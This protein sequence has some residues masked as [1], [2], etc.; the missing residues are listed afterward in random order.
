MSLIEQISKGESKLLEFKE[1]IP[2]S[3][4]L[5]K[6]II[7]FANTGGGKILIGVDDAGEI[8]GIP[9]QELAALMDRVA[10]MVHDA[11]Q[12][13]LI[14][15]IYTFTN[16]ENTI[17]VVEVYP[18]QLRPHYLKAKGK[19]EGTYIRVGATT[20]KAD[21]LYIAELERQKQNISYDEEITIIPEAN[22]TEIEKLIT[23]LSQ[24]MPVQ[25][26]HADLLNLKLIAVNGNNTYFT[27]GASILL[28]FPENVLIQCGRF[29]GV[30]SNTF[31][32][33]KT[34]T[35]DLF[36]QLDEAMK[37]LLANINL[38][39]EVGDDFLY[40]VDT[41][42]IPPVALR[43]ALLNAV[44]HRDYGTMNGDIKIAVYDDRIE[45]TSPGGFPKGVTV[46][47]AM[48]G[49]SEIRNRALVR[50]FREAHLIEQWGRG[51]YLMISLCKEAGLKKPKIVESGMF[52]QVTFYRK[53][54]GRKNRTQKPDANRT[55]NKKWK[56]A[57]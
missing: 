29:K 12:P 46:E 40:R 1:R 14:P 37:F 9:R 25:I 28:G 6:T 53:E 23:V 38:S 5:V 48:S 55:Q 22:A 31:I 33:R 49:R 50:V 43:E 52:V 44:V 39:G 19:E 7:A 13:L 20:R 21:S 10:N 8:V 51:I 18:S 45:I 15:E 32:D 41:Y 2:E 17:I 54:T 42:E 27:N 26:S 4:G 57:Y 47:E 34:L 35:G 24:R 16:E 3:D 36:Y 30:D 56:I 11:V